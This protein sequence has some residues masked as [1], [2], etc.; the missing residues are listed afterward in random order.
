[1]EELKGYDFKNLASAEARRG[2]IVDRII[3]WGAF[4]VIVVLVAVLAV[5]VVVEA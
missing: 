2:E 5:G 3:G 1:M 4:I